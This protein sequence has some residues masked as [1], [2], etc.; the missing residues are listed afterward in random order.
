MPG[1]RGEDPGVFVFNDEGILEGR[2]QMAGL[3]D[4]YVVPLSK[5]YG[6]DQ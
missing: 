2:P 6:I 5:I 1:L 3:H 4:P